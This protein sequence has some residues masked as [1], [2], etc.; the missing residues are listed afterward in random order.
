MKRPVVLATFVTLLAHLAVL[1]LTYS[2]T[3]IGDTTIP[4]DQVASSMGE[5][6]NSPASAAIM[7]RMCNMPEEWLSQVHLRRTANWKVGH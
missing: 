4:D 2:T 1:E 7:I 5:A 6:N 3:S